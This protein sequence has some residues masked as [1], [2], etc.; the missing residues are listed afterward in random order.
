M[1]DEF[2]WVDVG[3]DLFHHGGV[4]LAAA[5]DGEH[6]DDARE[7]VFERFMIEFHCL[8]GVPAFLCDVFSGGVDVFVGYITG[9]EE[10]EAHGRYDDPTHSVILP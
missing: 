5:F 7:F 9:D 1:A 3:D 2:L 6:G 10:E 8:V 4:G